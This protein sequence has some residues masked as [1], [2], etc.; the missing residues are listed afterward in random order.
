MAERQVRSVLLSLLG[1]ASL[2][3][4][5][6]TGFAVSFLSLYTDHGLGPTALDSCAAQTD[7][8]LLLAAAFGL[9]SLAVWSLPRFRWAAAGGLALLIG[10]AALR[11]WDAVV[12]GAGLTAHTITAVFSFRVSWGQTFDYDPGLTLWEEAAAVRL[13]LI[14]ALAL[15]ALLLG[16]S[17]VR[18][19]RWWMVM[20]LTLPPLLPGLLADLFPHWTP[21]MALCACWCAMVLCDLCKWAPPRGRGRLVLVMMVCVSIMLGTITLAFP[22]EGYTRPQW[23]LGLEAGL[24]RGG[25]DLALLLSRWDGPFG[26]PVTYVGSAEE[27]D[28]TH[29]GPLNYTGR[30]V[31]RVT[32][33]YEGRLYLRGSSLAVYEDGVWTGLPEGVYQIYLDGL[34]E[35]PPFP[36]TLPTLLGD[37]GEE[38]T[39]A[40]E[41]LGAVGSCAYAPYFPLEQDWREGG[42]LPVEDS[43]LA[44][45]RGQSKFTVAFADVERPYETGPTVRYQNLVYANY[46]DVPEELREPLEELCLQNG[47]YPGPIDGG[48]AVRADA[49]IEYDDEF[50]A[51]A[52]PLGAARRVAAILDALCQYD[53]QTPAAPQGADPVGY[54]LT[55][56]RR[57]YCMHYASAA[58]LMLRSLGIPARYTSGFTAESVPD[59]EVNVPDRAAHAWVEIWLDGFGW[60][61][62][63]VTPAAAFDWYEHRD[64]QPSAVPSDEPEESATPQPTPTPEAEPSQEPSGAPGVGEDSPEGGAG[65]PGTAALAVKALAFTAGLAALLWLVQFAIKHRRSRRLSG[66]ERNRAAL[67]AYSCLK[68]LE[69]WGGTVNPQAV[70]LAQKARFSQ[71][72]LSR[73]ELAA[74]RRLM[75]REQESLCARLGP[76][77]GLAFRYFWGKPTQAK[78]R[79]NPE[80]SE[81][82]TP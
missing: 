45:L 53:P 65:L 48:T 12:H 68:R 57:G 10:A 24:Q 29:A 17:V 41:N 8:F 14:L 31:L 62:V 61:P 36:L 52:D 23:A 35:E 40:I 46:L 60:Y 6:L 67:Y 58:A 78:N 22:R 27:A 37:P 3:L 38:H 55:Q 80:K 21:F 11:G 63:E 19:R 72:I 54:F 34:E 43:Y 1:D 73:E 42:M 13:F 4:C 5:A 47:L 33:D 15:L 16:W 64:A 82:N 69:R 32:S 25:E 71:H 7:L 79:E 9:V 74:L 77:K 66:P 20:T 76:I 75:D 81:E 18:A 49:I 39:A 70:E 30:T 28:L 51:A 59:R 56:S 26:A 2:L 50:L 44:R